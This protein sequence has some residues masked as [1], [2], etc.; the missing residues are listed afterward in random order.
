MTF[1]DCLNPK[2]YATKKKTGFMKEL[3]RIKHESEDQNRINN[4]GVF[5]EMSL[6]GEGE[7][8]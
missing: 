6:S 2:D 1:S 3:R 5:Q 4:R 7:T 8:W